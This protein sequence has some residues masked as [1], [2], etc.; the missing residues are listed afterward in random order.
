VEDVTIA[1]QPKRL[2]L[3][4]ESHAIDHSDQLFSDVISTLE[5]AYEVAEPELCCFRGLEV[6]DCDQT[7]VP[8]SSTMLVSMGIHPNPCNP[9]TTV[10]FALLRDAQVSVELFTVGGRRVSVLASGYFEAGD[11]T[12]KWDGLDGSGHTLSSGV[13]L[14][15]LNTGTT[16]L[17]KK[18]VLVR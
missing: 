14:V 1:G 3:A 11:H 6:S 2:A 16:E 4:V 17:T 8:G 7:S 18:V 15:R 10:T 12:L 13:Y 9:R 5:A